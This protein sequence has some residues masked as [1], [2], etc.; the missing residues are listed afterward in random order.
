MTSGFKFGVQFDHSKSQPMDDKL[1][2]IPERG[3]ITSRVPF[4]IFR[5]PV[6]AKARDFEFCT[7]VSLG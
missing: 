2:T 7:L 4:K 1:E 5:T 6:T 3:V